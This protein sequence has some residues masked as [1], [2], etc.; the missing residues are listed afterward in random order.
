MGNGKKQTETKDPTR[1]T[2]L[3]FASVHLYDKALSAF[4]ISSSLFFETSS[5]QNP[6]GLGIMN[7]RGRAFISDCMFVRCRSEEGP[8]G[9]GIRVR[10]YQVGQTCVYE[11]MSD[12]VQ[13]G[14]G[15][16]SWDS[17]KGST[18]MAY[19]TLVR[20]PGFE[21]RSSVMYVRSQEFSTK[22]V[23][24]S[25]C[26]N[27]HECGVEFRVPMF[28]SKIDYLTVDRNSGT[29]IIQINGIAM[30]SVVTISE[31][32][33]TNNTGLVQSVFAGVENVYTV[34]QDVI[35]VGNWFEF[36]ALAMEQCRFHGC[37]FGDNNMGIGDTEMGCRVRELEEEEEEEPGLFEC[38]MNVMIVPPTSSPSP[39]QSPSPTLTPTKS[40]T[41]T[42]VPKLTRSIPVPTQT[43]KP[44]QQPEAKI[45]TTTTT[46]NKND[47]GRLRRGIRATM[48]PARNRNARNLKQTTPFTTPTRTFKSKTKC[49]FPT[50]PHS[51]ATRSLRATRSSRKPYTKPPTK[52]PHPTQ[53]LPLT[54][55]ISPSASV[56]R[57]T[58]SPLPHRTMLMGFINPF[59]EKNQVLQG[60]SKY[61]PLLSNFVIALFCGVF[62]RNV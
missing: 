5:K 27:V 51:T 33:F 23:N 37:C 29:R 1:H 55:T 16:E 21:N 7:S 40:P 41:R 52:T 25:G 61:F 13:C 32:S 47:V 18:R 59:G 28:E 2:T 54:R 39:S 15:C 19:L 45:K 35:F 49:A 20:S 42:S 3:H 53:S 9:F 26:S 24:V 14:C 44:E 12:K 60:I 57:V 31:S 62:N 6:G 8:G 11:C 36:F 46:I 4:T 34:F 56:R 48:T 17:E 22:D 38:E 58:P 50:A 10:F 43:L 30:G